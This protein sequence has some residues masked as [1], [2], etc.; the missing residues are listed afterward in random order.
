MSQHARTLSSSRLAFQ[1]ASEKAPYT[2]RLFQRLA[3]CKVMKFAI[4]GKFN[5]PVPRGQDNK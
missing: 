3:F 4:E 2:P 1:M 5:I